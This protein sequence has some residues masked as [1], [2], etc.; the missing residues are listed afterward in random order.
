LRYVA[1]A[2][3]LPELSGQTY[4]SLYKALRE[5]V[6]NAIDAGAT[7]VD[8]DLSRVA[9]SGELVISDDG[10]GMS[11]D[12]FNDHFMSVG[13]SPNFGDAGT[14]GRIGIG[15]LA[16]L[17]Y[18]DAAAV[19]TKAAESGEWTVARIAHPWQMDLQDRRGALGDLAAGWANVM[20]FDGERQEHFTRL[21]LH[22]VRDEVRQIADD[23]VAFYGLID[24]LR[25][26]LP[27]PWA[28]CRLLEA[29]RKVDAET[30][31]GLEQHINEW[32]IDVFVH[33]IWERDVR[34]TR[35]FYGEGA[36]KER[37]SGVPR[38]VSKR[39]R[40]PEPTG[41]RDVMVA[42]FLLQQLN[43]IPSWSGLT[44]RVQN[45]AVEEGTFFDVT[46]DAG[47]RKYITG[48]MYLFG[49]VDQDRLINIDRSSFNR[50]CR[51]YSVVQRYVAREI[52]EF[53]SQAV[54]ASQRRKVVVRQALARR[55]EMVES[56]ARVAGLAEELCDWRWLP[57]SK[58][59]RI[60]GGATPTLK[61]EL[62]KLGARVR[63]VERSGRSEP[64]ALALD[65]GATKI[66][67]SV[68]ERFANPRVRFRDVDY[69]IT[70]VAGS[71]RGAPLVIKNRP[72][73][74]VFDTRHAAHEIEAGDPKYHVSFALEI[75]HLLSVETGDSLYEMMLSF[76]AAL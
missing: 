65:E 72:R 3:L 53:K 66:V 50:E 21:R 35:R 18:G 67:A 2:G 56:I 45:V 75:A 48:E 46:S 64:F 19:E 22:E 73:E 69:K 23:P 27:L 41:S 14:F 8:I 4:S 9:E 60:R 40:V 47:F 61:Q 24:T 13:G 58:N 74:I 32:A 38:I 5:V 6:L 39:L 52:H 10:R 7:R 43:V 29:L 20:P 1:R 25:R 36:D 76:A 33:S 11:L 12:E 15:S 54:Q 26:V 34:L 70:L 59:G 31:E 62:R 71:G 42:G 68:P 51:D 37:W 28:D 55:V 44:A 17:H 49:S 57:S 63:L 16:L 30:V